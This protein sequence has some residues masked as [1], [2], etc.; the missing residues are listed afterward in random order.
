MIFVGID[1]SKDSL[2][3]HVRPNGQAFVVASDDEGL[4]RLAERLGALAPALIVLEATGGLQTRAAAVLADIGLPVAVVNPRQVRDFA[5][6]TGRLAKTDRLDAAAIAHFAE[7][8][9][10]EPRPLLSEEA[11]RLAELIARRRQLVEMI[12]AERNRV[13]H[14]RSNKV[15]R[16]HEAV[17]EALSKALSEMDNDISGLIRQSPIW[18]V[19]DNLLKSVPGVGNVLSMTLLADLPELGNLSRRKIAALVGIAPYNRDSGILKGRRTIWGGRHSVR[20]V[21]YMATLVAAYKNPVITAIYKRLLAAGKPR[22]V[23]LVACMRKLLT[24]LNAMAR[25]GVP[26]QYA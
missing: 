14:V 24:I 20:Q 15:L 10:P 1:V 7:A 8:V 16:T 25:D 21:L 3:V 4:A 11:Q 13:K 26:W 19:K 18:R 2:D 12:T 5:K 22:K 17:M 23:A 9:R 6:A